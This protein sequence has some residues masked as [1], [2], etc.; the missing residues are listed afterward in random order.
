MVLPPDR[1]S[2]ASRERTAFRLAATGREN[3]FVHTG[4]I[5]YVVSHMEKVPYLG[6]TLTRWQVGPSTF[7]A[8]PEKGARLMNWHLTLGDGTVRDVVYWPE[9]QTLDDIA[10]V[11]GGN[12]VLFPFCGRTFDRGHIH[13]WRD[14][15]GTT[16]PMPIHGLARQGD[17]QVTRLDERGFTAL[18]QPGEEAR[19]SYPYD[20]EFT[21]SYRFEP[22]ALFVELRLRNLDTKPIPWSAGHHFY[23][24]LPWSEART[25][26]DYFIR[27]PAGA[28]LRQDFE[29]G[30]L[31][32]GPRLRR[33]E[34]LASK[35]LIDVFHT[36]LKSNAVVFGERGGDDKITVHLGPDRVPPKS[37]VVVT[38]TQADDSPFYCVEPWM[39]P[40]NSPEHKAGLYQV[41]PSEMQSFLVEV[42]LK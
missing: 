22:L 26:E 6:H 20:Y 38:W 33:E 25:R 13:S 42:S 36:A 17:F 39:G 3:V 16:R 4:L 8:L 5:R 1:I 24:T 34:S 10:K 12:P 11:R 2:S 9:L 28:S 29:N 19:A 7:L 18:F 35:D 31:H 32:P 41:A 27:I 15:N 23:F 37:A 14:E 21:V 30:Q 40:A